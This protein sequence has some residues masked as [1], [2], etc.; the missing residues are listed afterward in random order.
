M[1]LRMDMEKVD[2]SQLYS[3]PAEIARFI[4]QCEAEGENDVRHLGRY[5]TFSYSCP[6][7]GPNQL[8]DLTPDYPYCGPNSVWTCKRCA[9][10]MRL[11]SPIP[12]KGTPKA[13][14]TTLIRSSC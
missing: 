7:C 13:C 5:L 11:D 8:V 1:F 6:N 2:T 4:A 9:S 10:V 3:T 12:V 14:M